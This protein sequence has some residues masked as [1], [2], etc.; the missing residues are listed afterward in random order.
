MCKDKETQRVLQILHQHSGLSTKMPFRIIVQR[1]YLSFE[2][3]S[4]LLLFFNYFL[5]EQN[6]AKVSVKIRCYTWDI[7]FEVVNRHKGL[8][9]WTSLVD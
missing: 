7:C 9:A 6:K 8:S 1:L 3:Y 2:M 5:K 4:I